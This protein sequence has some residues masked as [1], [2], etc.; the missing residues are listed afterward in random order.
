MEW[1]NYHHL[2]YF[3]TV[4]RE[5]SVK[6]AGEVLQLAQPT[7]SGQIRKLEESLGETL[8]EREGRG[9]KLTESGHLVYRYADEIFTTGRELQDALRGRPT[10]GSAKRWSTGS[11][12][13]GPTPWCLRWRSWPIWS[14]SPRRTGFFPWPRM[15]GTMTVA[16]P[17]SAIA[18]AIGW[19]CMP[20]QAEP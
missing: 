6:R 4:A 7:L 3:Y 12:S 18:A 15:S 17:A 2:L 10:R 20:C 16:R 14:T 13:S 11:A 9:L 5:G 19:N 8:F 1:L